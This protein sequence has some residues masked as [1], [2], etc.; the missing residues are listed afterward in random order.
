LGQ[1]SAERMVY[2]A[3]EIFMNQT[4]PDKK[5]TSD[6]VRKQIFEFVIKAMDENRIETK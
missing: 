4:K 2:E 1:V 3:V 5:L 6:Q